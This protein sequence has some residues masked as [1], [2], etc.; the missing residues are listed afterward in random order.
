M[1]RGGAEQ[2][3]VELVFWCASERCSCSKGGM[4]MHVSRSVKIGN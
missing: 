1:G 4:Y 3:E 2:V